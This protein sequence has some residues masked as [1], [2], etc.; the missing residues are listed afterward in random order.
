LHVEVLSPWQAVLKNTSVHIYGDNSTRERKMFFFE[1]FVRFFQFNLK[2]DQL[3]LTVGRLV[4]ALWKN[5]LNDNISVGV[6]LTAIATILAHLLY[7]TYTCAM[8]N[9]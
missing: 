8:S 3:S 1:V 2:V 9:F 7:A 6:D 5:S 4:K